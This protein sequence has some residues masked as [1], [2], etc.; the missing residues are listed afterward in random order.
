MLSVLLVGDRLS[1]SCHKCP[2][3]SDISTAT[4]SI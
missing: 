4:N 1:E 3:D 2:F